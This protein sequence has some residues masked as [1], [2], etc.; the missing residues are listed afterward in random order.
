LNITQASGVF[1]TPNIELKDTLVIER[2]KPE[3]I[4]TAKLVDTSS[5][6]HVDDLVAGVK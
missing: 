6:N 4:T 3:P 2:P 1:K 5:E